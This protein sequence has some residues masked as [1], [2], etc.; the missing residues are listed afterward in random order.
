M[1]KFF[2][3]IIFLSSNIYCQF[4][5]LIFYKQMRLIGIP[6]D[7]DASNIIFPL[8]DQ[9]KDGFDDIMFYD[10]SDKSGYI[11]MG[12]SPMDTIP[13]NILHFYDSLYIGG[14]I[15]VIDLNNDHIK[16]IFVTTLVTTDSGYRHQG[17]LR[18]YYGGDVIDS[19]PNLT[20][21]P[22]PGIK[23]ISPII[24]K[25]FNGDGRNELVLYDSNLPYSS[26]QYGTFYFYNTAS[27]F[28]T[29]P[30]YIIM[31]DSVN[32]IR[33]ERISSSGDINGD[34][35][36]D[37]TLHGTIGPS[38]PYDRYFRSFYL[39]NENFDL[40]SDEIFYQ[41][42]HTFSVDYM[43]IIND[44]N[45]DRKDDILIHDYGF[46]NYYYL[47][48]ILHGSFPIDT[49]PDVG[50]NT[51]NQGISLYQACSLGD[52]NGDGFN[53][54]FST[55]LNFGYRNVKLWVGGRDMP[56]TWGDV[57]N[58][59]WHGTSDGFGRTISNV[60][61]VDGDGV[62]DILI[63][64][65]LY[66]SQPV[67]SCNYGWIYIFKG[68]TSVI[69]D[70]GAVNVKNEIPVPDEYYLY[71]P[72]P[73]PFNP[74]TT[75]KWQSSIQGH[76]TIKV[77]DILGKEIAVLINNELAAGQHQIEFNAEEYKLSSGVYFLNIKT[78]NFEEIKK[79][80]YLK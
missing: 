6:Q 50:L 32:Q 51:Q 25:D 12:G 48:A 79:M 18:V 27:Q 34:G 35:K 62:N 63:G 2:L 61:D 72:Y 58:K 21:N 69:G 46:Y 60:G 73:N 3:L 68:D 64:Q 65:I 1:N 78:G 66:G 30:Q 19:L 16:D 75:I 38:P 17:P 55:T 59:T 28:D 70:T 20:F 41:D 43:R 56:Y 44:I 52:V 9:N 71:E 14:A 76:T 77:F 8:G 39:G 31:G 54:F 67:T 53:D 45:G 36:T 29:I 42:E 23:G 40:Q 33:L 26:K 80:I 13:A 11:Y 10:C 47:N 74:S 5:S 24:L 57:A 22:P 37:F 49:I 7:V 4:D 15:T